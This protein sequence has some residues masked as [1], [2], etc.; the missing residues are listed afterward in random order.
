MLEP[1]PITGKWE[2]PSWYMQTLKIWSNQQAAM[3]QTVERVL[4]IPIKNI[5]LV[6]FV[7]TSNALTMSCILKNQSFTEQRVTRRMWIESLFKFLKTISRR[8]TENS[9]FPKRQ[10]SPT[11]TGWISTKRPSAGS[12]VIY[13]MMIKKLIITKS[14]TTVI[15]RESITALPIENVTSNSKSQISP[16]LY[17]IIW[18]IMTH[19]CSSKISV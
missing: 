18:P 6:C 16:H 13:L 11:K 5:N 1:L 12:A 17:S 2:F 15:S 14:E 4:P 10:S 8:Y 19:I 7:I 3:N 9:P